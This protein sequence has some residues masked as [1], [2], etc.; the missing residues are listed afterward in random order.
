M[1]NNYINVMNFIDDKYPTTFILGARGVGKTISSFVEAI[2]HC[3]ENDQTFVY[4]RRYDTE[5]ESL[6]LN[7][8]LISKLSGYDV[9][10]SVVKDKLTG[11]RS[12]MITAKKDDVVKNVGYLVAL[13]IAANYKSNAYINPWIVIYDEFIDIRGRELKNEPNLFLNF[14]STFFRKSDYKALFLANATDLFNAYFI[15]FGVMPKGKVTRYRKIGIK[16]V[17]YE[18]DD[19]EKEKDKPLNKLFLK[20]NEDSPE[21]TN[22]FIETKG[23]IGKLSKNAK[24]IKI[25]RLGGINYGLW[26]DKQNLILSNKYDPTLKDR[27]SVDGLEDGYYFDRPYLLDIVAELSRGTFKF[28]SEY[29]RGV[30]LKYLKGMNFI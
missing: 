13:S 7:L 4:M 16:I 12:K 22:R 1:S 8:P 21:L 28:S 9:N 24:N 23:F 6:G 25:I 15:S 10:V 18:N 2:K 19:F 5:I 20:I 17:M 3:Y 14:C 27:I 26:A 11:R 29:I 30:W